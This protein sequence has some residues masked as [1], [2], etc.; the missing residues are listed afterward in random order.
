MPDRKIDHISLMTD[1]G[2]QDIYVGVMKGVIERICPAVRVTDLSHGIAP[3]NIPLASL[4]LSAALPYFSPS[5]LHVVVV[6]PG[7]GSSRSILY[8][9]TDRGHFLAPD[10]GVL[11]VALESC[12]SPILHRVTNRELMLEETSDTFHGRDI[13]APVAANLCC[14]VDPQNLGAQVTDYVRKPPPEIERRGNE[15]HGQILFIDGFGNACTNISAKFARSLSSLFV[16]HADLTIE[17]PIAP[18]YVSHEINA[19]LLISNSFGFIEIALNQGNAARRY[20]LKNEQ[21]VQATLDSLR[22]KS[23][24]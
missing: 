14:G 4:M 13:F 11:T 24:S 6:D 12:G 17:G 9:Q 5:T 15:I 16:P 3:Q 22:H 20:G 8:A 18:S 10:N 21:R 1:F 2:L 19:P 23:N 7:V